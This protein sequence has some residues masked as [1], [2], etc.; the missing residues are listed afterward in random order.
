MTLRMWLVLG[1]GAAATAAVGGGTI[2]RLGGAVVRELARA[3][4]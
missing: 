1:A 2:G 4:T 3:A